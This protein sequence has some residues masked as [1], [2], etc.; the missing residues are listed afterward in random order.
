LA[1]GISLIDAVKINVYYT[2][3]LASEL[4]KEPYPSRI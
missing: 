4:L 2:D 1:A 3:D